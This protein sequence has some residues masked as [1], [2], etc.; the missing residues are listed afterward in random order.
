MDKS[1]SAIYPLALLRIRMDVLLETTSTT[2]ALPEER[3]T[4]P[5]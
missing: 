4:F 3:L 1:L 5:T 2:L